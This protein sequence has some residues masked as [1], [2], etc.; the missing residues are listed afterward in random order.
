MVNEE[1][2]LKRFFKRKDQIRLEPANETM[3]PII[4]QPTDD[5]QILG[6]LI[7]VVRQC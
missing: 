4:V 6:V 7:G 2:T 3:N 5:T 1:M